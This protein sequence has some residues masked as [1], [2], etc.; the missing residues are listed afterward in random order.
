[1][2]KKY[3]TF[4]Q[5]LE[6]KKNQKTTE[7]VNMAF[8]YESLALFGELYDKYEELRIRT[9]QP[10]IINKLVQKKIEEVTGIQAR[11]RTT[12]ELDKTGI[13]P[14]ILKFC[15]QKNAKAVYAKIFVMLEKEHINRYAEELIKAVN[16]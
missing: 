12:I 15:I 4:E 8:Y 6:E 10:N 13:I 5:Y 11:Y 3:P 2:V 16:K 1:M 9:S 14:R 7:P